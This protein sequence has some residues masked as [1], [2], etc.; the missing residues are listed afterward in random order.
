MH[1]VG[2]IIRIYHDARSP[3]DQIQNWLHSTV[4]L[5]HYVSEYIMVKLKVEKFLVVNPYSTVHC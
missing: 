5:R 2:F 4:K 1:L 3:E